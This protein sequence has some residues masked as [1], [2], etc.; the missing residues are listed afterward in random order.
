VQ[1]LIRT[2]LKI[3]WGIALDVAGGKMCWTDAGN[4]K[5]QRA[6]L[7]GTGVEDL[8]ITHSSGP[9]GGGGQRYGIALATA[10]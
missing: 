7:D 6:N 9:M 3:P 8:I 5:I 1:D 2:G 10:R 4:S